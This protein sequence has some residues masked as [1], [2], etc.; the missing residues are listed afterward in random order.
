MPGR[1]VARVALSTAGVMTLGVVAG[2]AADAVP[3]PITTPVLAQISNPITGEFV[4]EPPIVTAAVGQPVKWTNYG[5][6]HTVTEPAD[7]VGI[8]TYTLFDGESATVTVNSP[9]SFGFYC[10]LHPYMKGTL[11]VKP[12]VK[13]VNKVG[14]PV[15]VAVLTGDSP[16]R[17][18]RTV[19]AQY[20][21]GSGAWTP[22]AVDA[23]G[24][25]TFTGLA[26]GGYKVRSRTVNGG[27]KSGWA[28]SGFKV[29]AR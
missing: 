11:V 7:I 19:E 21:I 16:L 6:P 10:Q 14:D 5:A 25:I 20:R 23:D 4:Y 2:P 24:S 1:L 22:V 12:Y 8:Q 15:V 28:T 13:A 29:K 3:P 18:G 17:P 26:V 27:A 9:G